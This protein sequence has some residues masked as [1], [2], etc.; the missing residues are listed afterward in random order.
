MIGLYSKESLKSNL[1]EIVGYLNIMFQYY[2]SK[3][4]RGLDNCDVPLLIK[5]HKM[6]ILY[7]LQVI[8]IYKQLMKVK[9]I[10]L[11]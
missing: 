6:K 7:Y 5:L 3:D 11:Q 10:I 9:Y 1:Y 8:I 2:L 4:E